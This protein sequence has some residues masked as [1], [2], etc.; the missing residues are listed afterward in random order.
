[1]REGIFSAFL[2]YISIMQ[3]LL[4]SYQLTHTICSFSCFFMHLSS[5]MCSHYKTPNSVASRWV[6]R[7]GAFYPL[8]MILSDHYSFNRDENYHNFVTDRFIQV[9][10]ISYLTDTSILRILGVCKTFCYIK[11]YLNSMF[12]NNKNGDLK[13]D[14]Q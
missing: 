12:F 11:L 1:M 9:N 7:Q 14:Q 2:A 5:L 10:S 6:G 8:S 4:I 3:D 13:I